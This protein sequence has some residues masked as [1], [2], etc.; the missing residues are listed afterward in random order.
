M[1]KYTLIFL[2]CYVF[3]LFSTCNKSVK[4]FDEENKLPDIFPDYIDITLPYNIAP[5]NFKIEDEGEDF[6]AEVKGLHGEISVSGGPEFIFPIQKWKEKEI[7][8]KFIF[9]KMWAANGQGFNRLH[10]LFHLIL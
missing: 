7:L 4:S 3:F 10:G 8:L 5:L 1:N 2:G 6:K 9:I